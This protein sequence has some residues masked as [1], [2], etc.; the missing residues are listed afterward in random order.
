MKKGISAKIKNITINKYAME[1]LPDPKSKDGFTT[2]LVEWKDGVSEILEPMVTKYIGSLLTG[3]SAKVAFLYANGNVLEYEGPEAD[4]YEASIEKLNTKK[5]EVKKRQLL[6]RF[7]Q[8]WHGA[9][10]EVKNRDLKKF[11]YFYGK[12]K[13]NTASPNALLKT[14]LRQRKLTPEKLAEEINVNKS[15]IYMQLQGERGLSRDN[16]IKYAEK[17]K[18]D[19]VDLMFNKLTTKIWGKVNTLEY[20]DLEEPYATGRI[21]P[22]TEQKD[23]V[24]PRDI[25]TPNIKAIAIDAL[26]SMYHNQIA[27]YYRDNER[28]NEINNKLCVVGAKARDF[29]EDETT[30]YYFGLYENYQGKNN[31]L[32][33]DPYADVDKKYI[34]KNFKIEFISPIVAMIDPKSV[35]D[36]TKVKNYLPQ[37]LLES[38]D[39]HDQELQLLAAHYEA[40]LKTVTEDKNYSKKLLDEYRQKLEKIEKDYEAYNTYLQQ[41]FKRT[42]EKNIKLLKDIEDQL[43]SA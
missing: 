9:K 11:G 2:N 33:P 6:E 13:Y 5:N 23:V 32:N 14:A 34:L 19:P 17:L 1:R 38:K 28:N 22:T 15:S 24:V 36:A 40:K 18:V 10:A 41:H 7:A 43:K 8:K 26:G 12:S 25:Y 3:N 29:F 16:A 20:V 4:V 42:E 21:Y 39:S 31:L 30:F 37:Y 35:V 27:F